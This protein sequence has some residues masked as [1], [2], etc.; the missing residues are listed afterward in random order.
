MKKFIANKWQQLIEGP[1]GPF[2]A[3]LIGAVALISVMW[4]M[5]LLVTIIG[6]PFMYV[7]DKIWS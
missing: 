3:L 4:I 6:W 7:I 2:I 1:A 5:C